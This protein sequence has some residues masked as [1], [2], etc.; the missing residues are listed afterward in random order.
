MR[1]AQ[2]AYLVD[3]VTSDT[4]Q[5]F[6][7]NGLHNRL[8]ILKQIHEYQ[9]VLVSNLHVSDIF[10]HNSLSSE[11]HKRIHSLFTQTVKFNSTMEYCC[12]WSTH[13][14]M[15][16]CKFMTQQL[17]ECTKIK[18]LELGWNDM[19]ANVE[20]GQAISKMTLLTSVKLVEL[21]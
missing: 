14:S 21:I 15:D 11:S 12:I 18:R 20:L 2:F 1:T 8:A 4:C 10:F 5:I 13:L 17:H 3:N 7:R 6:N 19:S 9:Q 16:V